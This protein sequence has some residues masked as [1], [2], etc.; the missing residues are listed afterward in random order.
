MYIHCYIYIRCYIYSNEFIANKNTYLKEKKREAVP[1]IWASRSWKS[2]TQVF[3]TDCL[4]SGLSFNFPDIPLCRGAETYPPTLF[5]MCT[6]DS[7]WETSWVVHP[8]L[9]TDKKW[10]TSRSQLSLKLPPPQPALRECPNSSRSVPIALELSTAW[11]SA[12][13]QGFPV[14]WHS[15][16]IWLLLIFRYQN[17]SPSSLKCLYHQVIVLITLATFALQK[18]ESI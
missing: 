5:Q 4:T 2:L 18:P 3:S 9:L 11:L 1:F 14:P 12:S 8:K 7:P 15:I 6:T 16:T 13:W 10:L 17:L